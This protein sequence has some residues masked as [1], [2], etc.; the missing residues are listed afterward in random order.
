MLDKSSQ[1][2]PELNGDTGREVGLCSNERKGQ[3]AQMVEPGAGGTSPVSS[4]ANVRGRQRFGV[5]LSIA[6]LFSTCV[7]HGSRI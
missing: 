6:L 1:S 3:I 5:F 7:A 4:Q 2:H